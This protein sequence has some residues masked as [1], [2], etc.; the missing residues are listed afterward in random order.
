MLLLALV[1]TATMVWTLIENYF[2]TGAGR[3][4]AA[5]RCIIHADLPVAIALAAAW[6]ITS[7]ILGFWQARG[8]ESAGDWTYIFLLLQLV[9]W[10]GLGVITAVVYKFVTGSPF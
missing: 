2:Y 3:G 10:G 7:L 9:L 5:A 6:F 4:S 8:N 1:P